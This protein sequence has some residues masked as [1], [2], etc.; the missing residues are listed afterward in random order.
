MICN[1][2]VQALGTLRRSFEGCRLAAAQDLNSTVSYP[3]TGEYRD[4]KVRKAYG[5]NA[6][7]I[8]RLDSGEIRNEVVIRDE[9]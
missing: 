6:K 1:S 2:V 3:T 4:K 5:W 7:I 9:V 8:V